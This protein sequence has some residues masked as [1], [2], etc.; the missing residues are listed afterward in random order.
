M[1]LRLR[2]TKGK[3][4][5]HML[6]LEP[7]KSTFMLQD[8]GNDNIEIYSTKMIFNNAAS[9]TLHFEKNYVEP[10][11][12]SFDTINLVEWVEGAPSMSN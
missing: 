6:S 11:N 2:D 8:G 3:L 4:G 5:K 10:I 12:F 9:G 7:E 1:S